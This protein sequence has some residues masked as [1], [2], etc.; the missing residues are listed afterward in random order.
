[1]R[2]AAEEMR[3]Q[4]QR[5]FRKQAELM[6][7]KARERAMKRKEEYLGARVPR[8]LKEKVIARAN[9]MGIPVSILIRNVLEDAFGTEMPPAEPVPHRH[10][11]PPVQGHAQRFPHVIGWEDITLN[12]EMQC[13]GCGARLGAGTVVML[14]LP[15]PGEDHVILCAKC[16]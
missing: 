14:G 2:K 13:S 1:M 11:T 15:I 9:A 6:R 3:K 4:A 8:E 12:R 16:K 7:D 10:D 5:Q